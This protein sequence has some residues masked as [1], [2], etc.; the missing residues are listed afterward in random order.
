[1]TADERNLCGI[2]AS[3]YVCLKWNLLLLL[4]LFGK[5]KESIWVSVST[6]YAASLMNFLACSF[7]MAGTV[8]TQR[9]S[10]LSMIVPHWWLSS[11]S[12][13]SRKNLRVIDTTLNAEKRCP[14]AASICIS[15][16]QSCSDHVSSMLLLGCY[17]RTYIDCLFNSFFLYFPHFSPCTSCVL[18]TFL[19]LN[20]DDDDNLSK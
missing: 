15:F 4:L 9:T 14:F 20:E 1:M 8:T 13:W 6:S 5:F 7:Q 12:A 16:V 18:T 10:S 17:T 11:R 3:C 2:W 19:S